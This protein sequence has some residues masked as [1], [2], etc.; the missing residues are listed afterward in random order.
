LS[1]DPFNLPKMDFKMPPLPEIKSPAEYAKDSL[2]AGLRGF[3]AGLGDDE[4]MVIDFD[5]LPAGHRVHHIGTASSFVVFH[6]VDDAGRKA[7]T[8]LAAFGARVTILAQAKPQEIPEAR[9][10]GFEVP[11]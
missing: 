3:E 10:V 9:R 4:E 6:S 5:G 8:Y 1:Y 2:V 7:K 11:N